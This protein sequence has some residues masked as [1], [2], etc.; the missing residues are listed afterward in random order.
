MIL[1]SPGC[2]FETCHNYMYVYPYQTFRSEFFYFS[3]YKAA[4][5]VFAKIEIKIKVEFENFIS[6]FPPDPCKKSKRKKKIFSQTGKTH[7]CARFQCHNSFS[8]RET[9]RSKSLAQSQF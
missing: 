3:V 4:D 1:K 2:H 6:F 7:G 9:I 8:S 5:C